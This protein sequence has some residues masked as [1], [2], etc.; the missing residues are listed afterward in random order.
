[1]ASGTTDGSGNWN[2]ASVAVAANTTT[3]LYA[4]A[5][6]AA[7]NVSTCSAVFNYRHD[8]IAPNPP[9]VTGTNPFPL[10]NN[11]TPS[12]LGTVDETGL[13]V[14][15]YKT[16]DCS[17]TILREVTN[18]PLSWTAATVA[19]DRNT[20][21][22][23]RARAVD[24]ANN[25]SACST[26][27]ASYLHDD[28]APN[29]PTDLATN[30]PRWSNTV[31][32]PTVSGN[33]EANGTV[34][35]WLSANC[36]GT[37][38]TTTASA[39][40]AFSVVVNVGGNNIDTAI[41]ATV[42]DASGNV[43]SCSQAINYRWDT[44]AP[45]FAGTTT[46][47]IPDGV[48]GET[49]AN[50]AW[51][52]ATDNFTAAANMRYRV[53][54]SILCGATDC[55]WA[56]P[57]APNI[58]FTAAGIVSRADTDLLPNTRYYYAVRAVDEV[59]NEDANTTVFSGKT[60]GRNGASDLWVGENASIAGLSQG[61]THRWGAVPPDP[62][63]QNPVS[64]ALG[65]SHSCLVRH[66][67]GLRCTGANAL[68]QIGNGNTTNQPSWA[69]VT[70]LTTAIQV[71]VGLEH[72]CALLLNGEV[73]CWGAD[74][75]GQLGNGSAVS[76]SQTTPVIVYEDDAA[77]IPLTN[78]TS[79]ALGDF[80][81]CA[82][83]SNGEVWCWGS[84]GSG[85]LAPVAATSQSDYAR[86]SVANNYVAIT[87]GLE[88]T[89]GIN[90]SGHVLCWGYN[91]QGQLGDGTNNNSGTPRDTGLREAMAVRGSRRH[92]CAVLLDGTARCWGVNST[93]E[94]GNGA[95]A[96]SVNTP[97]TVAG[98]SQVTH[99]GGGDKYTCA[100]T[101]GGEAYCWGLGANG[102]LG[103]GKNDNSLIPALVALV[104][105][106]AS[107]VDTRSGFETNCAYLSDGKAACWGD[108]SAGQ[109][110]NGRTETGGSQLAVVGGLAQPVRR[111][112]TG[113]LH[114]CGIV[115]NG[116]IACWGENDVG[117][118]GLGNTTRQTSPVLLTTNGT[119]LELSLGLK[120][121]C[122]LRADRTVWCWGD[123]TGSRL[124]FASGATTTPR[125]VTG[126]T[127]VRGISV[128]A[129]HQCA[130]RLDGGV[131][132][133]GRNHRGQ[134]DGTASTTIQ[135]TPKKVDGVAN[136]IGVAAGE[137]HTCALLV[138]GGVRCWGDNTRRALGRADANATAVDAV[139]GIT[140][141]VEL[142]VGSGQTCV[143]R[144][145]NGTMRCWGDN[146][147]NALG[148]SNLI[149]GQLYATPQDVTV[150]SG[151]RFMQVTRGRDMGC[152][153]NSNGVPYCWGSNDKRE[154]G[155]GTTVNR[156]A[157]TPH[158][159]LP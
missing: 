21:T 129:E 140:D 1:M 137:A 130:V 80:H 124:G 82:L 45:T 142:A 147:L 40:G 79:L 51:T 56:N 20:T 86:R 55:D 63:S 33:A 150:P 10:G 101:A 44:V 11:A 126:I 29:A 70:G 18:A 156:A 97:V 83:K 121:S 59:G 13:R 73:R 36:T 135:T 106:V 58:T 108:N 62:T 28:L 67:G 110:G 84:N 17:G 128:G 49:R 122:S 159:C 85:Q 105:S 47:V 153:T 134:V 92:T 32:T 5:T 65:S 148:R 23:F 87:A 78:V 113:G 133:W 117:Q 116:Q 60:R 39:I 31:S 91:V 6:D 76:D 131:Y 43:S 158:I 4:A 72:S 114:S 3:T 145:L 89:C 132:C 144:L 157:P 37:S 136:A 42:T 141:A 8:N 100:R 81:G 54:R 149:E 88:H 151:M 102:R 103:T 27:S 139:A 12:V 24:A 68:G 104:S 111:V 2:I 120:Q 9:I 75:R 34:T 15:V 66:D 57:N 109:L 119:A 90:S 22:V 99:I 154:V 38:F 41:T 96:S 112:A 143:R 94:L 74:S 14:R 118:L 152:A 155:D 71:A 125:Q 93:G 98:L 46:V 95:T 77:T 127:L 52:A 146:A 50:V 25:V 69:T 138:G 26:T 48:D 123:N 64:F 7:G 30:P 107:V 61:G 16:A 19:A 35:V 115:A 53:C